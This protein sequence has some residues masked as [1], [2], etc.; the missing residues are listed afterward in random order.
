MAEAENDDIVVFQNSLGE[1]ISNDPRWH[2]K[3]VLAA[4]GG[5][6]VDA[7]QAR[8]A[9]LEAQ[10]A[11]KLPVQSGQVGGVASAD[12]ESPEDEDEPTGDY[13]E[14]KGAELGKLAKDRGINL[15]HED[16]TNLKAGEVRAALIAQDEAAK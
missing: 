6:D 5:V 16:G 9:E 10:L 4:Q 2:A 13:S 14:V 12:N 15:K 11:A 7:M 8:I 1:E 3:R